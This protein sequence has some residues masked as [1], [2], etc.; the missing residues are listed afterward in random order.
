MDNSMDNGME[1]MTEQSGKRGFPRAL[2]ITVLLAMLAGLWWG[3]ELAQQRQVLAQT[4][5]NGYQRAFYNYLEQVEQIELNCGKLQAC[6][7]L[8]AVLLLSELTAAADT[9]ANAVGALPLPPQDLALH[10]G[11]LH[12]VT[13]RWLRQNKESRTGKSC[14]AFFTPL[15]AAR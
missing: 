7:D 12:G 8:Q 11:W 13:G 10:S 9:A 6:A 15:S 3:I 4:V 14:P 2:L 1:M 5:E